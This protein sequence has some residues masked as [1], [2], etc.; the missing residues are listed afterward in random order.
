MNHN[1]NQLNFIRRALA[2]TYL[3][4]LEGGREDICRANFIRM[5]FFMD[6]SYTLAWYG[7]CMAAGKILHVDLASFILIASKLVKINEAEWWIAWSESQPSVPVT[8][9][10]EES[11]R[12]SNIDE[13][14]MTLRQAV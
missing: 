6:T 12:I 1:F 3:P 10:G 5:D 14:S 8:R 2:S 11:I 13:Q 4:E 9:A 7:R